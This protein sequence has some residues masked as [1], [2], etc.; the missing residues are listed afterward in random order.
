MGK[1]LPASL[2]WGPRTPTDRTAVLADVVSRVSSGVMSLETSVRM[3]QDAG[4]STEPAAEEVVRI[5]RRTFEA[6]GTPRG[7]H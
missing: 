5:Q 6:C 3:L 4:Y 7:R 2:A 1:P